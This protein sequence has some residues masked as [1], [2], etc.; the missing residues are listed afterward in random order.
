[1][2]ILTTFSSTTLAMTLMMGIATGLGG[3][4]GCLDTQIKEPT[5]SAQIDVEPQSITFAAPLLQGDD[6]LAPRAYEP[7]L[8][9]SIGDAV[10]TVIDIRLNE[11]DGDG[12][13]GLSFELPSPEEAARAGLEDIEASELCPEEMGFKLERNGR[14]GSSCVVLITFDARDGRP[15]HAV[16]TILSDDPVE[17][18]KTLDVDTLAGGPRLVIEPARELLFEQEVNGAPGAEIEAD[19]QLLRL[20]NAGTDF[21]RINQLDLINNAGG[22]FSVEFAEESPFTSLPALLAPQDRAQF[23]ALW[24]TYAP[25]R[26]GNDHGELRIRSNDP[27][28]SEVIVDLVARALSKCLMVTPLDVDYRQVAIG[29][30]VSQPIDMTNC[31]TVAI[32]IPQIGFVEGSHSDFSISE[33]PDGL[34]DDCI[35]DGG[36]GGGNPC[37]G[38]LSLAPGETAT[39]QVDYVPQA[40][41][42][43]GGQVAIASDSASQPQTIVNLFARGVT[44]PPPVALAEARAAGAPEWNVHDTEDESLEVFP[45]STVELRGAGSHDIGG[46]RLIFKWRILSKP[47]GAITRFMNHD[48][49]E[50]PTLFIPIS[51]TYHLE[52]QVTDTFGSSDTH[53][54]WIEAIAMGCVHVELIWNTPGDPDETDVGFGAGSDMDLHLLHP[55]GDW[56]ESPRDCHYRN[57]HPDWGD[58]FDQSDDPSLDIDDTDGGGPENITLD[59]CEDNRL[60]RVGVHYFNDHGYGPAFATVSMFVDGVLRAQVANKRMPGTDSFWDVASISSNGAINIIDDTTPWW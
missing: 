12:E 9:T 50:N 42:A 60:Y 55:L 26:P 25:T 10:L 30:D 51:G 49:E 7:L 19:R 5:E 23:I 16:L 41:G 34:S 52:V 1:M 33:V 8:I 14:I 11:D 56:G 2:K 37:E 32:G 58:A 28:N 47:D 36:A 48:A 4:A 3:C 22:D 21:L 38:D 53:E 6:G 54:V 35:G 59:Q 44:D 40:E 24:V 20:S 27:V 43:A 13:L 29:S 18:D 39:I 15:D 57:P 31:G 17:G 46:G 45:A